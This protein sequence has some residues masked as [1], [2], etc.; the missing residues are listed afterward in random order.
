MIALEFSLPFSC[1]TED[2]KRFSFSSSDIVT[3]DIPVNTISPEICSDCGQMGHLY[4][5]DGC[6]YKKKKEKPQK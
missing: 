6:S 3:V 1:L 5:L 4:G 2:H